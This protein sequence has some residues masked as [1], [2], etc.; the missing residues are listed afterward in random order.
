M[1]EADEVPQ[2]LTRWAARP[3]S[4]AGRDCTA[5]QVAESGSSTVS[6]KV[7]ESKLNVPIGRV[8]N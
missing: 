6:V 7:V 4:R 2:P 8:M 1:T 3:F 5:D